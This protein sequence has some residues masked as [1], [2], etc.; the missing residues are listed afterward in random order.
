[1]TTKP[2]STTDSG[3][4]LRSQTD[5]RLSPHP[6]LRRYYTDEQGRRSRIK[7]LFDAAAKDYDWINRMMSFGA[8]EQYRYRALRRAGLSEGMSVLDVGCGTGVIAAQATRITGAQGYVLALDPSIG[9]LY[10]A[11][12]NRVRTAVQGMGEQLP[13][14]D[15]SFD[16]L[17]MGYALRHVSDLRLAFAE[18]Q[19]VLKPGG[20]LLL[21]E[22]TPPSSSLAYGLL[23]LYLKFVVPNLVM[24]CRRSREAR[25]LMSYY[26]DTIERCVPPATIMEALREAGFEQ[27]ERH[28]ELGIFS[29]YTA[30]KAL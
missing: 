4:I 11:R 6:I 15:S 10:E 29:E 20:L 30:G 7:Q 16:R 13:F 22:I 21:L 9:M 23:K 14:A 12:R 8:G 24:L 1:M 27:V 28:V 5:G 2:E 25:L 17:I 26:W 18:Y 3:A 19:R